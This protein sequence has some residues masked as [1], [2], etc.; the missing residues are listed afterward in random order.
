MAGGP[1]G[2]L[3]QD[4]GA[5]P[6]ASTLSKLSISVFAAPTRMGSGEVGSLRARQVHGGDANREVGPGE[7]GST[8]VCWSRKHWGAR[9]HGTGCAS[10]SVC[11]PSLVP[12]GVGGPDTPSAPT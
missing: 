1:R 2:H 6:Q 8:Y 4:I 5:P 11:S 7:A 10:S 12:E 3:W 9:G